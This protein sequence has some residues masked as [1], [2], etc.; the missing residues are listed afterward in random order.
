MKHQLASS[1][2]LSLAVQASARAIHSKRDGISGTISTSFTDKSTSGD[3]GA[4][5]TKTTI[6]AGVQVWLSG[7]GYHLLSGNIEN[8]GTLIVSQTDSDTLSYKVPFAPSAQTCFWSGTSA[9]NGNLINNAG[10]TILLNDA[11]ATSAP[12]YDWYLESFK[13]DGTII[14]CGR[15]DTGGSTYQLYSDASGVNNGLIVFEQTRGNLGTAA[16]WRNDQISNSPPAY[17]T[18]NGGFLM[19][20]MRVDFV[21][22][23]LGTGCWMIGYKSN[24]YL[25]DGVGV[26][27]NPSYG[28]SF[29]GQSIS[30]LDNTGTLHMD[31]AVYAKAP[32]FGARI[33]G[34]GQG[35]SLEFY[36]TIS[37]FS[38][39]GNLLRVSFVGGN[40]VNLDIGTGYTASGFSKGKSGFYSSFNA[41]LYSGAAPSVSM[42]AQ[43]LL[44]APICAPL[45]S[46]GTYPPGT[47]NPTT[48]QVPPPVATTSSTALPLSSTSPAVVSSSSS[49][50]PP[51]PQSSTAAAITTTS[52]ASTSILVPPPAP[53]SSSAAGLSSTIV[54]PV[55]TSSIAPPS[56]SVVIPAAT[57]SKPPLPSTSLECRLDMAKFGQARTLSGPSYTDLTGMTNQACSSFCTKKGYKY[58]GTEYGSECYCGN[59][60]PS[61]PAGTCDSVCSGDATQICGGSWSLSITVN[62]NMP[63]S[64]S[65]SG[66]PTSSI[67][68]SSTINVPSSAPPVVVPTSTALPSTTSQVATSSTVIPVPSLPPSKYNVTVVGCFLE[69]AQSGGPRTLPLAGY[70]DH[71]ALTNAAC[72]N[73]CGDKGF[74]YSG[75]EYGEECYCGSKLP[76]ISSTACTSSCS[77][78]K[79]EICGGS[80]ALT[81]TV[82]QDIIDKGQSGTPPHP[83]YNPLGC[84]ADSAQA[85]TFTGFSYTNDSM[86]PA[87][88]AAKCSSLQFP[89]S[90][91]EFGNE[92]YCSKYAPVT[93]STQCI[94]PCAGNSALIC[95]GPDAL[96]VYQDATI[97]VTVAPPTCPGLPAGYAVCAEGQR[98]SGGKCVKY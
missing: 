62:N 44:T 78:N 50:V 3:L 24:M 88:C 43:C 25:Q 63:G 22:N 8:S 28:P 90:G 76:T 41:I 83:P 21:Q 27:Q 93:T 19:R 4:T 29:S 26:F 61:C 23:F 33:Y 82:N 31:T 48:S 64:G 7:R 87:Q 66:L 18:N 79:T 15:G 9:S 97:P 45:T 54:A 71:T 58:S 86:T 95:G 47:P 73:F 94:K 68:A 75:T 20:N 72:S 39:E 91:T 85:R 96:T 1:L 6:N 16:V 56:T 2:L 67:I 80:W 98:V 37:S 65:S 74:A 70:L 53:S 77:G 13:N 17:L 35:N 49:S 11:G 60:L 89:F 46:G 55:T 12:T 30:F 34:F 52:P 81:V 40:S 59:D 84:F 32:N 57:T 38:Y 14:W 92:C 36:Q 42:P 10:A 5:N 69:T 51:A